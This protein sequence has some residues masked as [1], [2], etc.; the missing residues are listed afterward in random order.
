MQRVW[1]KQVE[2]TGLAVA[3]LSMVCIVVIVALKGRKVFD[4]RT[5]QQW[6]LL[7]LAMIFVGKLSIFYQMH[8][9]RKINFG[10]TK[11]DIIAAGVFGT[12]AALISI[13]FTLMAFRFLEAGVQI[14]LW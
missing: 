2:Y 13:S 12:L 3:G 14:Y 5:D 6:E 7:C 8:Y 11:K 10:P 9:V 1:E 4:W